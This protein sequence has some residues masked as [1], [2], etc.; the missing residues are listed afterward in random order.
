[1]GKSTRKAL[2]GLSSPIF[3]D[4]SQQGERLASELNSSPN[5]VLDGA[6]GLFFLYD[7]VWF[8]TRCLCPRNMRKA[9]FVHFLDEEG[10]ITP[11]VLET[12]I[13]RPEYFFADY[14]LRRFRDFHRSY[15]TTVRQV[16]IHWEARPDNHTQSLDVAGAKVSASS[17]VET[18]VIRDIALVARLGNHSFELI[19]NTF[20]QNL[21]DRSFRQRQD[22]SLAHELVIGRIPN[23][24]GKLGPYHPCIEECRESRYLADFRDWIAGHPTGLK[25]NEIQDTQKRV[26]QEITDL[27]RRILTRYWDEKRQ[28]TTLGKTLLGKI[29]VFGDGLSV[30][31]LL[32]QLKEIR[33]SDRTRWQGFLLD[34][35]RSTSNKTS[36]ADR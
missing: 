16:G 32:A 23:Y 9:S 3:Y 22:A 15:W 24:L 26:E 29:P 11:E 10:L 7:E 31:D 6:Y 19:T 5:P 33:E 34:I 36:P 12:N 8:L 17:S 27:N 18:N 14:Q 35:D 13:D 25:Q 30:R 20:T 2:I 4:Y 1:M 28:Y 21:F